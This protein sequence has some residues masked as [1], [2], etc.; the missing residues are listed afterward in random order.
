MNNDSP[1]SLHKKLG[2]IIS[3]FNPVERILF[4]ALAILAIG[5]TL[6]LAE[7]VNKSYMTDVPVQGGV[8][9]EGIV[10]YAS[11][12]NPLLAYT[13]ADKDLASLIYSGLLKPTST[14][15]LAPDL[16]E[17]YTVSD[18]GLTYDFKI[19]ADAR[20]QDGV[21]VTADDIVF[22]IQQ[23][24]NPA[25]NSPKAPNWVGVTVTKV[26]DLEVTLTLKKA[27]PAFIQNLTLGILPKHKWQN[28]DAQ[29]FERSAYNQEPIG[30]GPYMVQTTKKDDSGLYQYYD[31]VPFTKYTGGEAYISHIIVRF[32]SNEDAAI[33]AYKDGEINSI[34]GISPAS[35]TDLSKHTNADIINTPLPRVFAVFLNQN[36]NPVFL[37]K[38][39]RQALDVA[40]GRTDLI[41]QV[42][43]GYAVPATGPI[44]VSLAEDIGIQDGVVAT[45]IVTA[46]TTSAAT[47][48]KKTTTTSKT[49]TKTTVK[50]T[51]ATTTATTTVAVAT[52]TVPVKV[53]PTDAAK[54]IL[55]NAGWKA[56]A[57]GILVKQ[58]TSGKTTSTQTLSFTLSTADTPELKQSVAI[59]KADWEAIGA[60]VT[61]SVFDPS[62][63]NS[64]V[65]KPRKYDA[66]LFGNAI[67]RDL[68]LYQFWD[69]AERNDP[70]LNIAEY[71]NP[72]TDKLLEEAR[73]TASTTIRNRD[74]Q[75]FQQYVLADAPAVF[76]YSP[77]FIY[78]LPKNVQ[79]VDI[80]S[81]ISASE[82]FM[83]VNTWYI[84]TQGVWNIFIR[85]LGNR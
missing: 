4:G 60:K 66:L 30:S 22:T 67:G 53:S 31:L 24:Q 45:P 63:L 54:K 62:D 3:K 70:G 9:K 11:F 5:S 17:S 58:V 82:R 47:S 13:D 10:G 76:L 28:I 84:E 52:T 59:L 36:S 32:Y 7:Y 83:N 33:K 50:T 71:V 16:A 8:L 19:R 14:G 38:E 41:D 57:D 80:G 79:G 55:A 39:V 73:A 64:Q 51:T 2:L 69:S 44:P 25:V 20:F 6:Y 56:G 1:T 18:D 65:I 21:A 15:T 40:V 74:Y 34:A 29:L 48:T 26:N 81:I 68:D 46:A 42:F 37:N 77:D 72:K 35:A 78:A 12:I 85:K 43:A 27:Y 49:T 23:V 75:L 61:V